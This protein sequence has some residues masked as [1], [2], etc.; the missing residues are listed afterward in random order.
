[1]VRVKFK[2]ATRHPDYGEIEE[3]EVLEVTAEYAEDYRVLGFA[4]ET[5]ERLSRRTRADN[6]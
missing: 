4:E 3:G 6:D 2:Q 1:M 5:S